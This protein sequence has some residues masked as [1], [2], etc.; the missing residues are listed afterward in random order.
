[1]KYK[2]AILGA[3]GAVGQRYIERLKDH[4]WFDLKVLAA[5]DRSSGKKYKNTCRWM[6]S[7][8][9]PGAV[10]DLEVV[11]TDLNKVEDISDIDIAF[12]ALPGSVAGPIENKFAEEIPVVS[13]A[14]SHRMDDHVPLIIPEVNPDHLEMIEVQRENYDRNGF[15]SAD[16]NCS[17]IQLTMSLKPLL[18]LGLSNVVVS[19]MQA[20]SGAGYPGVS[21][22]DIIDNILPYIASEEDKLESEPLKILGTVDGDEI[23]YN[24][25]K[26]G[27]T[28]NRVDLK[29]GHLE[30]I[31]TDIED[32]YSP[33]EVKEAFRRFQGVYIVSN[34]PSAPEN[35]LVVREEEDRPQPRLDRDTGDGMS[36]VLGRVR[37]DQIHSVK[38]LCLGH[39]T[40][41][42]AAGSGILHAELLAKKGYI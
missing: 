33:D 29:D 25:I 11:T 13:K 4:P 16:P 39:N 34:L 36:V 2:A 22:M 20:L 28:C 38:Y 8:D 18:N 35:P 10:K 17:T 24:N 21:S 5:S 14:S 15:I 40:I 23:R 31:W 26:I 19:T 27:A 41:R 42:G 3:T 6:L 1:M 9:M 7:S 32:K 12:S 30:T 37:S